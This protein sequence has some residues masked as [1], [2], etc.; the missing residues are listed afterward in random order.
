M[1]LELEVVLLQKLNDQ[2]LQV[3]KIESTYW[4]NLNWNKFVQDFSKN[5]F[6]ALNCFF[7][8]WTLNY[9]AIIFT[10]CGFISNCLDDFTVAKSIPIEYQLCLCIQ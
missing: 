9:A 10:K 2:C 7:H 3:R 4:V 5:I 1:G 6:Y 8:D